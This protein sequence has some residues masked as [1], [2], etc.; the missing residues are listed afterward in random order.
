MGDEG[1][2]REGGKGKDERAKKKDEWKGKQG[3]YVGKEGREGKETEQEEYN[4][5]DKGTEGM[6]R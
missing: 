5:S 4:L 1:R 6:E 2:K 3:V